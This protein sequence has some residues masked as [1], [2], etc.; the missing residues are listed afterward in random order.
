MQTQV[1]D[2]VRGRVFT[3]MD[4]GWNLARIVSVVLGGVLVDRLGIAAV[5]YAGGTLLIVA[6]AV[7]L[8]TV[9]LEGGIEG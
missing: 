5:Y 7:G 8:L 4:M 9:G 6:G 3:L 2:A 1:P